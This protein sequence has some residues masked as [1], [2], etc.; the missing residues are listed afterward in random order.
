MATG[1]AHGLGYERVDD[2]PNADVLLATMDETAGWDAT[3]RL[4]SWERALLGINNG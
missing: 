4:R 1:D 2:D 3:L